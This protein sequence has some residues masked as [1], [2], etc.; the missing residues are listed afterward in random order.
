MLERIFLDL[1]IIAIF[2]IVVWF[3]FYKKPPS[4]PY[5]DLSLKLL[6][7][8]NPPLDYSYGNT[9]LI[10]NGTYVIQS[11][12]GKFLKL[13]KSNL[14]SLSPYAIDASAFLYT[15]D[16]NTLT[17]GGMDSTFVPVFLPDRNAFVLVHPPHT[18]MKLYDPTVDPDNLPSFVENPPQ[19]GDDAFVAV[20]TFSVF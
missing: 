20:F 13:S 19:P 1:T 10:P 4:P 7:N 17:V 16:Q 15:S 6:T 14:F 11:I 3:A 2:I 8:T 9:S 18:V 5:A 12:D